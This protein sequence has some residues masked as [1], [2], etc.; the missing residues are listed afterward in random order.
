MLF[1]FIFQPRFVF[2]FPFLND[3]VRHFVWAFLASVR[4]RIHL[5]SIWVRSSSGSRFGRFF[6]F[7]IPAV[8]ANLYGLVL[9]GY[10]PPGFALLLMVT[11]AVVFLL[12]GA[13]NN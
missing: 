6:Q 9:F 4:V 13:V 2:W 5:G 3:L 10:D 12:N 7:L 8:T 11:V 1:K